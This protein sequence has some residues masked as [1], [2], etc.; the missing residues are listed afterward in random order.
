MTQK[1]RENRVTLDEQGQGRFVRVCMVFQLTNITI[2]AT[3]CW[4]KEITP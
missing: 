3:L 2:F 1:G 4:G